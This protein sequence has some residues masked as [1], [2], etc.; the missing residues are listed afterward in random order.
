M[1]IGSGSSN[2]LAVVDCDFVVLGGGVKVL[3]PGQRGCCV[4]YDG[5]GLV[6][7]DVANE[8]VEVD[9]GSVDVAGV[10]FGVLGLIVKSE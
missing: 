2:G 1:S 8:L 6:G 4:R 3:E 10:G 5:F 9:G 7:T